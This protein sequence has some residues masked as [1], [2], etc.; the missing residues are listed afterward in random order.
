MSARS[1]ELSHELKQTRAATRTYRNVATAR[2]DG[3]GT[4][5]SPYV[6]NMG[7]HFVNPGLVAADAD[8]EVN[9]SEPPI[10]VYYTTGDYNPGPGDVHDPAHD[11]D[12]RL[13]AVEFAHAETGVAGNVFSDESTSRTLKVSESDG[14]GPIPG[15]PLMAVH[16]WVHRGNPAGVFNPTNPTIE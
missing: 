8:T 15:A 4:M 7:F 10:L 5:V 6:P 12:L 13:G 9:L 14:W 3:Y 11:D 16:V 1:D 2:E